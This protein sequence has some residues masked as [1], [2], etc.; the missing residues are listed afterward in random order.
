[1]PTPA[2]GRRP[3]LLLIVTIVLIAAIFLVARLMPAGRGAD[4]VDD[5]HWTLAYCVGAV[6]GWLG[7]A[8]APQQSRNAQRWFAIGLTAS[9]CG[10]LMWDV[11]ELFGWFP[12]PAPSD[13]LFMAMGPCCAYGMVCAVRDRRLVGLA[14]PLVLDVAMLT[15]AMFALTLAVFLPQT[16]KQGVDMTTVSAFSFTMLLAPC[17]M[18]V[19]APTLKL[20]PRASTLLFPVGLVVNGG[21]WMQWI[22]YVQQDQL[23]QNTWL[24]LAFSIFSLL[25]GWGVYR[26]QVQ[27]SD[28][29]AWERRCEAILRMLPLAAVGG[30]ALSVGLAW[31]L[32]DVSRTVTLVICICAAATLG[33][34]VTRQSLLLLERDQLIAAERHAGEVERRFQ[35]LF[36]TSRDGFALLNASGRFVEVNRACTQL[37]G[38]DRERLLHMSLLDMSGTERMRIADYLALTESEGGG[39]LQA[40]FRDVAGRALNLEIASAVLPGEHRELVMSF[41]DVSE[42]RKAEEARLQLEAQLRQAQKLEAIGTLASGIAHD[43]NNVLSAILGNVEL[44]LHDTARDAPSR[45]S[46]NEIRKAGLRARELIRRIVAFARP[47]EADVRPLHIGAAIEEAVQLVRATL[48]PAVRMTC[49]VA[50]P[51]PPVLADGSQLAQV[52]FNLCTNAYQAMPN[53]IGRIDVALEACNVD[54]A[55]A[56]QSADLRVGRY[57]CLRVADDGSGMSQDVAQRIF[58]PFFTTKPSGEGSGLGLSIVHGI[59]RAHG[60]AITV[61][62][63]PGRGTSFCVYLPAATNVAVPEPEAESL[64]SDPGANQHILYVDDEEALVFLTKRL[65]ERRG[66]RV[67]GF[68]DANAALEA[69]LDEAARFDLVIT[70]QSMPGLCGIDLAA[71]MLRARPETRIVLVSGYLQPDEVERARAIGTQEVV[72]KPNTVDELAATVHRLLSQDAPEPALA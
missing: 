63:E 47:Q 27:T 21:L 28:D 1:M 17:F 50:A 6:F 7:Y 10:Q 54:A 31:W 24:Y 39:V 9:L 15:I 46:L 59:V 29:P 65:L 32:P 40:E 56:L 58:E 62:S 35:T 42:R 51:L 4:L 64:P 68:T 30:A 53:H 45:T 72:L 23:L 34:A 5:L 36:N 22:Y 70:D 12:S 49:N 55:T 66:Y 14:W 52:V 18:A 11:Q 43:F 13:L 37:F 71:E 41:R 44:A 57:V 26:W 16:P 69:F 61:R 19:V 3:E 25:L 20:V 48:P 33:L 2:Q 8:R 38:A 67:T 60:G